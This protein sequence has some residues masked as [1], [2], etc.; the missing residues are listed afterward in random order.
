MP[1]TTRVIAFGILWLALAASA[2]QAVP[3]GSRPVAVPRAESGDFLLA[4]WD[5][6][7]SIFVPCPEPS[8]RDNSAQSKEGSQLDPDGHQ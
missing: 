6:L 7:V 3:S 2:L 5:W 1:R 8:D 4:G